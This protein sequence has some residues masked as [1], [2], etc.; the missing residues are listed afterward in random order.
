M[1][2]TGQCEECGAA[3]RKANIYEI[4]AHHGPAFEHWRRQTV[5]AF[6]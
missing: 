3:A 4:S 6:G 5:A 1:S 2:H